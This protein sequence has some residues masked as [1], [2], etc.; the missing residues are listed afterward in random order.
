MIS[1]HYYIVNEFTILISL[2]AKVK[3]TN[4]YL[5]NQVTIQ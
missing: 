4:K 3:V 2:F 1:H 5:N